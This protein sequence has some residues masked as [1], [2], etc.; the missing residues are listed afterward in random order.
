MAHSSNGPH[1]LIERVNRKDE[2]FSEKKTKFELNNKLNDFSGN[3]T[4]TRQDRCSSHLL[5]QLVFAVTAGK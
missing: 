4:V 1:L 2:V 3:L 5:S